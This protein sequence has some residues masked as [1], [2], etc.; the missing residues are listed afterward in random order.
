MGWDEGPVS[1]FSRASAEAVGEPTG[2]TDRFRMLIEL[3]QAQPY[4]EDTWVGRTVDLGGAQVKVLH[5]LKRCVVITQSPV[6]GE[7]DWDGLHA[8]NAVRNNLCLGVIA[9]VA[10]PGVVEVGAAVRVL[11]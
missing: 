1:L 7:R 10:V 11:D 3:D 8:L 2:T 4:E 6:D 9:E 5:P